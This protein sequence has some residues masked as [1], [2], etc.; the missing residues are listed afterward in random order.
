MDLTLDEVHGV[1]QDY[2][3]IDEALREGFRAIPNSNPDIADDEEL[4]KELDEI[5]EADSQALPTPQVS[6]NQV[7]FGKRVLD[8]EMP[9]VPV[10]EL[11]INDSVNTAESL[12]TRWKR[13][14]SNMATAD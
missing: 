12:E 6:N 1:I 9:E 10:D 2:N 13:L 8:M 3:D 5:V 4:L 14:R 11:S 7:R